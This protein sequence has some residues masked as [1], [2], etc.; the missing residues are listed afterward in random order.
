MVKVGEM[1]ESGWMSG[2]F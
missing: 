1:Q 2:F